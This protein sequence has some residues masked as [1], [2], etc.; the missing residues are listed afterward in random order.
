MKSGRKGRYAAAAHANRRVQATTQVLR[1]ETVNRRPLQ[2]PDIW[3]LF[4]MAASPG[5]RDGYWIVYPRPLMHAAIAPLAASFSRSSGGCGARGG[6]AP[7]CASATG[8]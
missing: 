5:A 8:S 7:G 1:R 4:L 6:V 3:K 2:A